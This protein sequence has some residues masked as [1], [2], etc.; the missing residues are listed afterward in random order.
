MKI[1]PDYHVALNNWANALLQ[2]G[3]LKEGEEAKALF[4]QAKEKALEAERIKPGAGVYNAACAWARLGEEDECQKWL[5]RCRELGKLP[6][7]KHMEEDEDLES[8]RD[9][10]WFK[11][12]LEKAP[13]G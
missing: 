12:I 13:E 10:E 7:R 6:P 9:K 3:A 8:V 2:R 1:K 4:G 5:E 11:E